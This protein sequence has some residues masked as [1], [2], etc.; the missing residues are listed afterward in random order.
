MA[1]KVPAYE[2]LSRPDVLK[3]EKTG[4]KRMKP[5]KRK[6]WNLITGNQLQHPV[7]APAVFTVCLLTDIKN[8]RERETEVWVNP[9]GNQ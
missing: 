5:R 4:R 3:G 7:P 2:E 6:R 9:Y 8:C 1:G